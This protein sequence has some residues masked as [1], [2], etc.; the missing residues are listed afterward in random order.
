MAEEGVQR[1]PRS[2]RCGIAINGGDDQPV[3]IGRACTRTRTIV[4]IDSGKGAA[5]DLLILK[6]RNYSEMLS[7]HQFDRVVLRSGKGIDTR[8]PDYRLLDPLMTT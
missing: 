3:G 5:A 7:R 8:L 1:R 6:A 2:Q 4:V